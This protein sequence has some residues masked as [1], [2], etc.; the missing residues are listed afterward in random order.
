M[1]FKSNCH[2]PLIR[3]GGFM[4]MVVNVMQEAIKTVFKAWFHFSAIFTFISRFRRRF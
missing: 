1:V 2:L 3:Y 4:L